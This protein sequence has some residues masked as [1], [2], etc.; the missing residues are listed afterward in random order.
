[1]TRATIV[2]CAYSDYVDRGQTKNKKKRRRW[3]R[4]KKTK[5][6]KEK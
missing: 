6:K 1:V 2:L 5:K 4:K 3:R